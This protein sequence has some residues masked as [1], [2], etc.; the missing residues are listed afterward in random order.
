M[1]NTST[2]ARRNYVNRH[3]LAKGVTTCTDTWESGINNVLIFG[4]SGAGKT[5]HYVK[6]NI[7]NAHESL[8]VSDTKGNLYREV[9]PRLE[10][11]GYD[12]KVINFNDLT[13]GYGYNPLDYIRYDENSDTYSEQDII[14]LAC[15]LV[16]VSIKN[17]PYWDLAARQY[18]EVLIG[19]VLEAL[20]K[21]E[22][23]L[24]YVVKT[25]HMMGSREL[26]NLMLELEA[27]NPKGTTAIRYK[28]VR[29]ISAAEKMDA[30]IKGIL[31]T[32]LDTLS[33]ND[34][35]ALYKKP[36]RID[37]MSLGKRKTAIFLTISD[38]DRSMDK[39]ANAFVTQALQ[40]LCR[41]ADRDYADNRL[42]VPV[43]FYLDDFAT[44]VVIPDFDKVISVIR[45]R[46]IYVSI[47]LQSVT[48]LDSLYGPDRAKTI[49]NNCDQMLYLGGQDLDTA[50]LISEKSDQPLHRILSMPLDKA[51]LFIR[52][53]E[54]LLTEKYEVNDTDD[55]CMDTYDNDDYPF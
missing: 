55:T 18:L 42:P 23:T 4:P 41:S 52:G 22:H 6:P 10:K 24:E 39:L 9:G 13:S 36:D 7:L 51:Y 1:N 45:S 46:E 28:S 47:I 49:I 53:R 27:L 44:N 11:R 8:I 35:L 50:R 17:D 38:T 12:V 32:N 30:S 14:S 34:A 15:S 26:D 54:A 16:P 31:S 19:Y 43:R 29:G 37:F 33:F 25:M 5:R 21:E 48:Q 20:P 40:N 3:I 2:N